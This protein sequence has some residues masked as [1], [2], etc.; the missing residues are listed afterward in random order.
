MEVSIS[1]ESL[2]GEKP[3]VVLAESP[4]AGGFEL[5]VQ[6]AGELAPRDLNDDR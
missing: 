1:P 5:H 4:A 2:S 6:G 3:Q